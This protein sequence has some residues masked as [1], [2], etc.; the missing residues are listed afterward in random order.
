V[1]LELTTV[2][3]SSAYLLYQYRI[4][5]SG[6]SRAGVA[7]IS[8]DVAA[9]AGTG[10]VKLPF[11]GRVGL[12]GASSAD[13]V[14]VGGIAPDGWK[15]RVR[16]NAAFDWYAA[17]VGAVVNDVGSSASGDSAAPGASK[18][19]FGLRSPYLPGI[20][21]FL[22]LPTYQACCSQPRL[23]DS[24]GEVPVPGEFLVRGFTVAPTVRSQDMNVAAVRS[25]LQQ[26][27]GSLRWITDERVCARLR[28]T[29]EQ[30]TKASARV[31]LP[32]AKAALRA[33][34][35]EIEAQHGPG[36]PVND[37]AYW[38]LNVNGEYLLKQM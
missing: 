37:N 12:G 4:V 16:Y 17:D 22:A 30:V 3:D 5:N 23:G 38:L 32:S 35:D 27:C 11:T 8:V 18:D 29:L 20:R 36:R 9:R 31:D 6:S 21:R 7:G 28:S 10:H 19:G 2:V 33:F 24:D 15:M 25:D 1:A 14:P 26:T 13:H 34:V